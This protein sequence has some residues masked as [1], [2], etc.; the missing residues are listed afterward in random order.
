MKEKSE[1]EKIISPPPNLFFKVNEL[2]SFRE[3]KAPVSV[4][5]TLADKPGVEVISGKV[6][7]A[8]QAPVAVPSIPGSVPFEP[9]RFAFERRPSESAGFAPEILHRLGVV[10]LSRFRYP[11]VSRSYY[12]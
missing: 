12:L 9:R 4:S 2:L 6:D 1:A 10:V 8:E 11:Q 7:V 5:I 3:G